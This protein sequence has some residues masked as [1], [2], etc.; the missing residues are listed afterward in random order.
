[1]QYIVSA[2]WIGFELL[3]CLVF[4]S[5]FQNC[6]R[7]KSTCI[8]AFLLSWLVMNVYSNTNI[9]EIF[10][11]F[12]TI[13]LFTGLCNF[14]YDGKIVSHLFLVITCYI[15]LT[16][17]DTACAYGFCAIIGVTFTELIWLKFTYITVTTISKLLSLC[18]AW[19]FKRA[20]SS[21]GTNGLQSRWFLLLLLFPTASVIMLV[22][23]FFRN[24]GNQDMSIGAVIVR[25][26]LA[27]A[28]V[29]QLY[30]VGTIE[31]ATKIENE[32]KMLKQQISFQTE[33]YSALQQS[34]TLQRK[35]THEFER[36]LQTMGDLLSRRE[37]DTAVAYLNKLQNNHTLRIYS[38]N[39]NH[40]VIDVILNQKHQLAKDYGINMQICVNDLSAV[41]IPTDA[42]VVLLSNLLDNAIEACQRIDSRKEIH[43]SILCD[44]T[45]Y[46]SIRNTSP[47]VRV[48]DK[49]I[50]TTKINK[51]DHGY[52][53][54]AICYILDQLQAEYAFDYNNG[55]FQFVA[56]IPM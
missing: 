13:A 32:T 11:Q 34:Y 38:V 46:I 5:S 23:V 41:S 29:V 48:Q 30:I 42:L 39:S 21:G 1:M 26:I 17:I 4:I 33:N 56:E 49:Y 24:Q 40:A 45:V 12:V 31:K 36:H 16:L 8:I 15:F 54:P 55:W 22:V 27:V 3:C 53:I 14:L 6:K 25:A 50:V 28:N 43:C 7:S 52:G 10:K 47:P 35:A 9:N 37:V 44:D 19:L 51:S 18:I 2:L 20:R